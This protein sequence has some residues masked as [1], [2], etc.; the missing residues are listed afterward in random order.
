MLLVDQKE[1]KRI[2]RELKKLM[3]EPEDGFRVFPIDKDFTQIHFTMLGVHD[4]PYEHG[5]YHGRIL[6]PAE[7]PLKA[8]DIELMTPNGRWQTDVK[9]CLTVTSFHQ[10]SWVSSWGIRTVLI[11]LRSMMDGSDKGGIG[12]IYDSKKN[13]KKLAKESWSYECPK[14]GVKHADLI[15]TMVLG[16]DGTDDSKSYS[17]SYSDD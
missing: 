8:P 12:S 5:L 1:T 16:E 6:L 17:Y 4:S 10:E 9:I 11:G 7:Y 2:L 3:D 13:R 14:C 15:D